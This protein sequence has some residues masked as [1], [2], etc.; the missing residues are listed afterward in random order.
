MPRPVPGTS[1][2][3]VLPFFLETLSHSPLPGEDKPESQSVKAGK[4]PRDVSWHS[5]RLGKLSKP[6]GQPEADPSQ[7]HRAR[8]AQTWARPAE[9]GLG[10][11]GQMRKELKES[12]LSN[13]GPRLSLR[14]TPKTTGTA[15]V[16]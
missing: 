3:R 15:A 1:Q 13:P 11:R 2:Q 16:Y 10:I 4:G 7:E 14:L 8:E 5:E 9:L 6:L 12:P